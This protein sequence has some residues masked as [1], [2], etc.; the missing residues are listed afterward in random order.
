MI[1]LAAKV[2][3]DKDVFLKQLGAGPCPKVVE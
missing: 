2:L 3:L 1:K